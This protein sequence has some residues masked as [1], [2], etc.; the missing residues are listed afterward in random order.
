MSETITDVAA[1]RRQTSGQDDTRRTGANPVK[2]LQA[3]G[4]SVWLDY[5]RRSLFTSG[6]FRR[7]IV[8]DGLRGATS[9]PSIFEKAIAGS[10]DYLNA[11]Q[12]IERHGDMTPMA[13]YEALAIRDIR[14]AADLLR[15][16]YD[17]TARAD[18]YVSLEV[19]PYIAHDTTATINE[20]RRL[21]KAVDR[22]NVMIKVPA[23]VEGLPAIRELT[24]EGINVNI[25]LLFGIERYEAVARGVHRRPVDIRARRRRPCARMQR[26]Q[27]LREPHR[28]DGR[29]D[30]CDPIGSRHRP[31]APHVA[32][33]ASR[34]SSDRQRQARL[35]ALPGALPCRR[36]A[37]ARSQGRA[38]TTSP[39][40]KHQYQE[41]TLSRRAL[42]RRADWP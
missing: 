18:G 9:N 17:S 42:R 21:W 35:S 36:V 22:E 19:S 25:T 1:E 40:G 41:S 26:R 33:G 23:S 24:S 5:L 28:H 11:L 4:Q 13:L 12:E 7:L 16:V 10:T 38:S 15:P 31:R 8:E 14:D 27:L 30:H 29:R 37:A 32:D 34:N 6:E 39:V 2:Q 20:A 3:F